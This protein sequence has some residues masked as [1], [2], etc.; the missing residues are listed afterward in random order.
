MTKYD[1]RSGGRVNE[2]PSQEVQRDPLV[3]SK[4]PRRGRPRRVPTVEPYPTH[5][6]S[7]IQAY[8]RSTLIPS[9]N[10]NSPSKHEPWPIFPHSDVQPYPQV[11]LRTEPVPC[12]ERPQ[13][14]INQCTIPRNNEAKTTPPDLATFQVPFSPDQVQDIL[15]EDGLCGEIN[16]PFE[17]PDS[18]DFDGPSPYDGMTF[19]LDS[20]VTAS[21]PS[22]KPCP[23]NALVPEG[24][25]AL[26]HGLPS[27]RSSSI[28]E[29]VQELTPMRLFSMTQS[30]K[31]QVQ[32]QDLTQ[33][34][35][36]AQSYVL[37]RHLSLTAL[38]RWLLI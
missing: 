24:S 17:W 3:R 16:M 29:N 31:D 19:C 38:L 2:S 25:T 37:R 14:V 35:I 11:D 23:G 28:P 8:T 20:G 33:S 34:F 30:L 4:G 21:A 32:K 36:G 18:L 9:G 15:R 22:D 6:G 13:P 27:Q 26:G 5:R 12:L 10:I 1:L 7:S